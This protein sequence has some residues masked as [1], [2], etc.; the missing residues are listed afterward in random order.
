MHTSRYGVHHLVW[1]ETHPTMESAI[2]REKQLKGR[3]RS[4]KIRLI[5]EL[6]YDWVGLYT[7]ILLN[8]WWVGPHPP[9]FRPAPERQ[10]KQIPTPVSP[11][12]ERRPLHT[13]YET[14]SKGCPYESDA[15]GTR[16]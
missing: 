11:S 9:G 1:Y 16:G 12:R 5:E 2:E 6:S 3:Y 10:S 14:G 7:Q 15:V 13:T 8:T 4:W